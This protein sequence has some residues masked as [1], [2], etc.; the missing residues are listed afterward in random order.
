MVPM[1]QPMFSCLAQTQVA[2]DGG[3]SGHNMESLTGDHIRCRFPNRADTNILCL[4]LHTFL[5]AVKSC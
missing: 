1:A 5:V 2:D 4:S 3:L